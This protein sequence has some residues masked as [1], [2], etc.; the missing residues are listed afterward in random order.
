MK[1][2][3]RIIVSISA[4]VYCLVLLFYIGMLLFGNGVEPY[5]HAV[6]ISTFF[7]FIIVFVTKK[8]RINT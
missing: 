5:L 1:K 7:L 8:S 2:S 6:F 4:I 3:E